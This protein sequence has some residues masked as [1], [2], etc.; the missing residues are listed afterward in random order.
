[1]SLFYLLLSLFGAILVAVI[2][3]VGWHGMAQWSEPQTVVGE[4][5]G[6]DPRLLT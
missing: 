1:M 2:P 5:R 3:W 4:G 6:F